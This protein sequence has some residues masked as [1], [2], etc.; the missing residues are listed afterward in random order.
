MKDLRNFL[1]LSLATA[2][3]CGLLVVAVPGLR[4]SEYLP[5]VVASVFATF[6]IVLAAQRRS[7]RV[8]FVPAWLVGLVAVSGALIDLGGLC[9][10]PGTILAVLSGLAAFLVILLTL[11][12]GARVDAA[13]LQAARDAARREDRPALWAALAPAF[14]VPFTGWYTAEQ[15]AHDLEVLTLAAAHARGAGP[16]ALDP[17]M[18]ALRAGAARP[19]GTRLERARVREVVGWLKAPPAP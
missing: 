8:L 15:C 6:A 18:A 5:L 19:D 3:N 4:R 14:H 17:V 16:A 7:A 9:L 1:A 10:I 11:Q 12:A 2:L 13:A